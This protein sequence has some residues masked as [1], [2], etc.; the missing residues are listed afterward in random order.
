[1]KKLWEGADWDVCF[2]V[3]VSISAHSFWRLWL[4]RENLVSE[5]TFP[6]NCGDFIR[7]NTALLFPSD[8]ASLVPDLGITLDYLLMQNLGIVNPG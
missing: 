1:M 8:F 3:G 4:C 7:R 2:K 6:P 5:G